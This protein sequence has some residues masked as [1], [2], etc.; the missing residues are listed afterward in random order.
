M[1]NLELWA[2]ATTALRHVRLVTRRAELAPGSPTAF[3]AAWADFARDRA[4]DKGAFKSPIP[5]SNLAKAGV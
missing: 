2:Q 4:K 5:K 3:V 1:E